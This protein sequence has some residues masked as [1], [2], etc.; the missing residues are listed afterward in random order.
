M[1][2]I[3]TLAT[4]VGFRIRQSFTNLMSRAFLLQTRKIHSKAL[5]NS[6]T[7]ILWL[8]MVLLHLGKRAGAQTVST[9]LT[10]CREGGLTGL[11]YISKIAKLLR[12]SQTILNGLSSVRSLGPL[13]IL[14]SFTPSM[15]SLNLSATKKTPKPE[16]RPIKTALKVFTTI[17]L[18]LSKKMMS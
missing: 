11:K 3:F 17:E 5:N 18:A 9:W 6:L 1:E 14:D 12:I 15:R 4:T 7:Q 2:L 16:L 13:T 8:R 10:K